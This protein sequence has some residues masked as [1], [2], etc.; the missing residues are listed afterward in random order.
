MHITGGTGFR[1]AL[2]MIWQALAG[3]KAFSGICGSSNVSWAAQQIMKKMLSS[4]K[5]DWSHGCAIN[6]YAESHIAIMLKFRHF[7]DFIG[8]KITSVQ[9]SCF[10]FSSAKSTSPSISGPFSMYS[11]R[12]LTTMSPRPAWPQRQSGSTRVIRCL[13][14]CCAF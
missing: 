7:I 9:Q 4:N 5:L 11:V 13:S 8:I 1:G 12:K 14:P 3:S 6:D 2:H 10:F